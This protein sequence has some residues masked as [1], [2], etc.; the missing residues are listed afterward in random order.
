M[1][2]FNEFLIEI[3]D[4]DAAAWDKATQILSRKLAP[5]SFSGAFFLLRQAGHPD[6]VTVA[7]IY[8]LEAAGH[9]LNK[10]QIE[11]VFADED[12]SIAAALSALA[13]TAQL[14]NMPQEALAAQGEVVAVVNA[15]TQTADLRPSQARALA[16]RLRPEVIPALTK[17]MRKALDLEGELPEQVAQIR[18]LVTDANLRHQFHYLRLAA[19]VPSD[20]GDLVVLQ[21]LA[22]EIWAENKIAQA[23]QK[24]A[25]KAEKAAKEALAKGEE[26]ARSLLS[27]QEKQRQKAA[28][29]ANKEKKKRA[30]AARRKELKAQ[31]EA[32]FQAERKRL[33]KEL[34]S[35]PFSNISK[36]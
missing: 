9:P 24:A 25:K 15:L 18:D 2:N 16:A 19:Q 6:R 35:S 22:E 34:A 7:D 36:L 11:A 28:E 30:K 14:A 13:P 8:A 26:R 17:G 4:G 29:K 1:G 10:S 20:L 12:G 27:E 21:V 3:I 32:A 31:E 23:A 5:T 33:E